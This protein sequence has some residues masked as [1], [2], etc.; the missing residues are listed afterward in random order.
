MSCGRS[1][2]GGRTGFRGGGIWFLVV[3]DDYSRYLVAARQ[4]DH[5]PSTGE[6]TC[7]AG[8]TEEEAEGRF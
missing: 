5:D 4:F 2:S 8:W 3:I 7:C 1:T 6:V